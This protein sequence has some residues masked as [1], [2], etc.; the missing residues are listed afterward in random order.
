MKKKIILLSTILCF[1]SA[2][3][4]QK[5]DNN[6]VFGYQ[7]CYAGDSTYI[8][9]QMSF[10]HD[11]LEMRPICLP[12]DLGV[13][14]AAMST[15]KGEFLFYTNSFMIADSTGDTLQNSVGLS[16]TNGNTNNWQHGSYIAQSSICLPMPGDSMQYYVF[17]CDYKEL[18]NP[19]NPTVYYAPTYYYSIVTFDAAHPNGYVSV[20]NAPAVTGDFISGTL[21]ACK[22]GNGRDWWVLIPERVTSTVRRVLISPSGVTEEGSQT[23]LTGGGGMGPGQAAFSPDGTKYARLQGYLDIYD[24]DRCL[25]LLIFKETLLC[26]AI[27]WTSFGMEFSPNSRYIY[28]NMGEDLYQYDLTSSNV[29]S[30]VV[31]I[32]HY[33]G[34]TP[35]PPYVPLPTAFYL[36]QNA[37]DGKIYVSTTNGTPYLHVI[38]SPD[39]QGVACNFEQHALLLEGY[40][41]YGMANFP[42]YRLGALQGSPCDTLSVSNQLAVNSKQIKVYPNPAQNEVNIELPQGI[43]AARFLLYNALGQQ[44]QQADLQAST[45]VRLQVKQG[46]YFYQI[47]ERDKMVGYGKLQVE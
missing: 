11:T 45:L 24:F 42:N 4:A 19:G 30:S 41:C 40:K 7:T 27:N 34:F 17:H 16:L 25:G 33:D 28:L 47:F 35:P 26:P 1:A 18:T 15:A 29:D 14:M 8:G 37:P 23:L 32:A 43:K 9:T 31:H 2:I 12:I 5:H 21:T 20:K 6:W 36:M 38:H 44:V 10:T 13:T 3:F 46:L 22:H 39:S